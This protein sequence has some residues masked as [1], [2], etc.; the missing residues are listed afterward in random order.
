MFSLLPIAGKIVEQEV[1]KQDR[2]LA[3]IEREKTVSSGVWTPPKATAG[4]FTVFRRIDGSGLLPFP[5]ARRR[6]RINK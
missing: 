6:R 2:N 3:K 1:D 4:E 5:R